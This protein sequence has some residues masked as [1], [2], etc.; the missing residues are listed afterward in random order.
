MIINMR[1][2]ILFSFV[3]MLNV[4]Y[5]IYYS[6]KELNKSYEFTLVTVLVPLLSSLILFFIINKDNFIFKKL[7]YFELIFFLVYILLLIV[8]NLTKVIYF[9]YEFFTIFLVIIIFVLILIF[10]KFFQ[11]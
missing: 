5:A 11:K 2:I 3:L 8:L 1:K 6:L 7:C 9:S 10:Y 4:T